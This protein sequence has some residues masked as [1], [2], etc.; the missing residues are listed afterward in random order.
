MGRFAADPSS[1]P[2]RKLGIRTTVPGHPLGGDVVNKAPRKMRHN[3]RALLI[4]QSDLV[5]D[6]PY[7]TEPVLR[8]A[9]APALELGEARGQTIKFCPFKTIHFHHLPIPPCA[10]V[11][12][13]PA[14]HR[15]RARNHFDL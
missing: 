9:F 6:S 4:N 14:S 1:K 12:G 13:R 8:C 15:Q 2:H 7:W 10:A 11:Q 3:P 5:V